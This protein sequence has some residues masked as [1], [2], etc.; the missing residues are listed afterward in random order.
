MNTYHYSAS[1]I[2]NLLSSAKLAN[3]YYIIC[4]TR[5]DNGIYV[6]SKNDG[7]YLLIQRDNKF[8]LYYMDISEASVDE[9][10]YINAV[11]IRKKLLYILDQKRA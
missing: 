2:V 5:V 8:N 4:K 7:K 1:V 6:Q 10:C 3:E 11:R 9:H